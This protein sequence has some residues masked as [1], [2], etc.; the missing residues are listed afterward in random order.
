MRPGEH[1]RK[2]VGNRARGGRA[3]AG[4]KSRAVA[5]E[6]ADAHTY[7]KTGHTRPRPDGKHFRSSLRRPNG[8]GLFDPPYAPLEFPLDLFL[9]DVSGPPFTSLKSSGDGTYV[10]HNLPPG[11]YALMINLPISSCAV[12]INPIYVGGGTRFSA[13]TVRPRS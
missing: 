2:T 1:D 9:L 13:Y 4:A 8:N 10:F 11:N 7:V 5:R 3:S 12:P 6:R